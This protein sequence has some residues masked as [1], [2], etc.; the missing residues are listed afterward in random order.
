[1][2]EA[3]TP[4]GATI[5]DFETARGVEADNLWAHSVA[6]S[7]MMRD[8]DTTQVRAALVDARA[9]VE[10][11]GESPEEL[12]GGPREHAD[13]LFERWRS[14][15]DLRL[16]PVTPRWRDLPAS[17]LAMASCVAVLLPLV[18]LFDK[19]TT[20]SWTVGMVLL[21]L[22]IG[23]GI[24][25]AI[26]GWA[27]L[28][29]RGAVVGALGTG[30]M[31]LGLA[32]VAALAMYLSQEHPFATAGTWWYLVLAAVCALLSTL[33]RRWLD[34][35]PAPTTPPVADEDE[36]ARRLAGILRARLLL[37][38]ER[39]SAIVTEARAHATESGRSLQ[40]EF[41]TPE[42]YAARFRPDVARRG[43][44]IAL[45]YAVLA[46]F[47]VVMLLDGFSWTYLGLVLVLGAMAVGELR[48]ARTGAA[49]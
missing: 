4:L 41:G 9:L 48:R 21:P 7:L 46:G 26:T 17:G 20:T 2:P 18:M 24:A 15:G 23:L 33:W 28:S 10:E 29:R 6:W 3:T 19:E 8:V 38:E 11:T 43:R 5:D 32:T 30:A 49:R 47:Y 39:V 22:V 45:L 36:W 1:M 31:V 25:V 14:E 12:F 16:D 37:P 42:R 34:A 40:E 27:S 13:A 44:M 35:H